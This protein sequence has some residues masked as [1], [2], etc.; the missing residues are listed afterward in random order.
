MRVESDRLAQELQAA[1]VSVAGARARLGDLRREHAERTAHRA[2]VAAQQHSRESAV[3]EMRAGLAQQMRAAYM[4]G[5]E[6][7][8]KLLLNQQGPC[9]GRPHVCV[10]QLFWPGARRNH[11]RH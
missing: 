10:L 3:A 1:E 6:E 4:M 2:S 9:Q 8:L 11:C 5:P 7:P